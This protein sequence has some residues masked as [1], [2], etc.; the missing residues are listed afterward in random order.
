MR[1]VACNSGCCAVKHIRDF[2]KSPN[3]KATFEASGHDDDQNTAEPEPYE[4][5]AEEIDLLPMPSYSQWYKAGDLFRALVEQIKIRRPAG[6][7]TVNLV[8][9]EIGDDSYCCY[10]C[11]GCSREEWEKQRPEEKEFNDY[12][13][14]SWHPLLDELGFTKVVTRNSN[15]D[16][17]IHH[18]TL[19]YDEM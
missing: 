18:Y 19:V 3:D 17:Q 7:I 5:W 11:N 4:N 1:V 15:T 14:K 16:N 9:E 2:T 10:D 12:Q 8:A 13:V 6:I